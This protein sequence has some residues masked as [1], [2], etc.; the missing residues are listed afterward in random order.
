[1]LLHPHPGQA[2]KEPVGPIPTAE[3]PAAA[4]PAVRTHRNVSFG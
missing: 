4:Q 3:E 1:M 2:P